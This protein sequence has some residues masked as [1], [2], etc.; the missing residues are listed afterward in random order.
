VPACA[1]GPAGAANSAKS[2][3]E[4]DYAFGAIDGSLINSADNRG[5]VT[6]L[7]FGASY[8]L[9]TQAVSRR[10]NELWHSHTPRINVALLL[11]E[12]PQ[13]VEMV[14][15]YREMLSI[16]YPVGLASSGAGVA[17]GAFSP[18]QVIPTWIFLDKKGKLAA[19]GFGD[20]SLEVLERTLDD[21]ESMR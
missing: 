9:V 21:V 8:D 20:L 2:N 5:R 17:G 4:L 6:I 18:L 19:K 3:G 14:R 15:A 13:N 7:L 10:L 11:L 1:K 12:P 16:D